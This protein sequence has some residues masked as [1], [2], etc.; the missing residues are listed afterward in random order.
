[1]L[2]W[3]LARAGSSPAS[4]TQKTR[5]FGFFYFTAHSLPFKPQKPL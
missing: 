2:E 5:N 3:A 1:L 4:S